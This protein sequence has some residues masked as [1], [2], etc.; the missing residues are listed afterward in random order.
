VILCG[1]FRGLKPP[2]PSGRGK[3]GAFVGEGGEGLRGCERYRGPSRSKDA[4]RMTARTGND[5]EQ[6]QAKAKCG[7][8]STARRTM[9]PSAAPVGMRAELRRSGRDDGGWVGDGNG[10]VCHI[11]RGAVRLDWVLKSVYCWESRRIGQPQATAQPGRRE[12]C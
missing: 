10:D 7:G 5:E 8:P 3:G 4:L 1:L 12:Y 2:A 6:E 11:Q 9:Q